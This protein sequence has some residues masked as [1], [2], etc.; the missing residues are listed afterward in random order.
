MFDTTY[1]SSL[2]KEFEPL[3]RKFQEISAKRQFLLKLVAFHTQ[4][5]SFKSDEPLS[6]EQILVLKGFLDLF[7]KGH[8]SVSREETPASII[9]RTA[10][11]CNG[12]GGLRNDD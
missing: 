10:G 11:R 5:V 8:T 3:E 7:K 9:V 4:M 2:L 1:I 6:E 12:F